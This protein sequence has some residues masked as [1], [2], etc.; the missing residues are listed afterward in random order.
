MVTVGSADE[1]AGRWFSDPARRRLP[2]ACSRPARAGRL[3]APVRI[4]LDPVGH[5]STSC[6]VHIVTITLGAGTRPFDG[7]PPLDLEQV[8]SRA[9]SSVTHLTYRVLP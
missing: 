9:T 5:S 7:V 2:R 8:E 4:E 3:D 1:L 6:G